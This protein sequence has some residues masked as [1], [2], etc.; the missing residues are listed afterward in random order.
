MLNSWAAQALGESAQ[1]PQ[2][3]QTQSL[4][5]LVAGASPKEQMMPKYRISQKVLH[6]TQEDILN[7]FQ[8]SS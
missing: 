2:D 1:M 3:P 4:L 6:L 7:F 5:I 8:S